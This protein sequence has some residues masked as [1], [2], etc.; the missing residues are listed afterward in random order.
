MGVLSV[1][2]FRCGSVTP[3]LLAAGVLAALA[4]PASAQ[5]AGPCVSS[6]ETAQA[7]YVDQEFAV[8]EVLL[9]ECLNRPDVDAA[10]AVQVRR[11]L[12]L[13]YLRQDDLAEAKQ[14]V[15]RLLGLAPD[16][17]PDPILDP[18]SYVALVESIR[19]SLRI[20]R[21]EAL[22]DLAQPEVY[23][24]PRTLYLHATL[25]AG[26]YGGERGDAADWLVEEFTSNAGVALTLGAGFNLT[27]TLAASLSYR[28][29]HIPNLF[30][31]RSADRREGGIAELGGPFSGEINADASSK[32]V[33][34]VALLGRAYYRPDGRASSYVE[35]GV[36]AAFSRLNG[37]TGTGFGPQGGLGVDVTLSPQLAGFAGLS[38][39]LILPGDAVDHIN[40][41]FGSTAERGSDLLTFAEFGV[42]YRLFAW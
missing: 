7:Y 41:R 10:T 21:E 36:S 9:R 31:L 14:I 38:A 33:H 18:P 15:I 37:E 5:Q 20:E 11:L 17:A 13:V 40:V 28:L 23:R 42:R 25:G 32:W 39:V 8:A 6:L 3:L 2:L 16:Y 35:L 26:S 34:L 22:A 24:V 1:R 19:E 12:A 27:E 30:K 29:Q 4:A